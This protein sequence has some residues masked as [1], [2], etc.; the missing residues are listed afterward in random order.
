MALTGGRRSTVREDMTT[1]AEREYLWLYAPVPCE[2]KSLRYWLLKTAR[3]QEVLASELGIPKER[4]AAR[5]AAQVI[6]NQARQ[7]IEPK[8]A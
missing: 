6:L 2:R 8:G 4:K 7:V 1:K 5:I 3:E